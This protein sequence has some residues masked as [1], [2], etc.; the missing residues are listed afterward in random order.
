MAKFNKAA[1]AVSVG[2][3]API[4]TTG[5]VSR[6]HEGGVGF[7]TDSKSSLF[8]LASTNM[9]GEARFYESA[10]GRDNRF[11]DLVHQVTREDPEWMQ[12]FIPYLRNNMFMRS[13]SVAAACEYVAAGGPNGRAVINSA[14][15]RVDELAEVFGYWTANYDDR[16][17]LS[18][19]KRAPK[20]PAAVKRGLAD[21]CARLIN[22]YSAMKYDSSGSSIRLGDV[23]EV[24]HPKPL[25]A[26]QGS[27]FKYLLDKRHRGN[28]A[29]FTFEGISKV[30]AHH[31]LLGVSVEARRDLITANNASEMLNTAGFTWEQLSGWLQG[32]MDSVAWSAVIPSMAPMAL[33]RNLR[34]FDEAKITDSAYNSV[35]NRITDEEAIARAKM[36]P[37]RF[38]SAFKAAPTTR[39]AHPLETALGFACKNIPELS[40]RTLILIDY[41]GSMDSTITAKSTIHC[42]EAAALFG[43]AQF[44][45]SDRA[46]LV[47]FGQGSYQIPLSS[48]TDVLTGMKVCQDVFSANGGGIY[49]GR[50]HGNPAYPGAEKI[51]HA[52]NTMQAVQ[53][54]F[55]PKVHDRIVIFSDMQAWPGNV[56]AVAAIKVPVYSFDLGGYSRTHLPA[57]EKNSYLLSGFSDAAFT[58]MKVIED[59][60]HAD[61]PFM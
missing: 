26:A 7:E 22:E 20:L 2:K 30:A 58:M 57:G 11:R 55:N 35:V 28:Q 14:C 29:N 6:T 18:Y 56:S 23:L 25:N 41:S 1:S 39:W 4:R 33:I 59:G 40:G 49:S 48:G 12:G 13:A 8:R 9:C 3:T 42:W 34:N 54:H 21:A 53:K 51:G 36:F 61:W 45:R 44:V 37:F 17:G 10:A 27:L 46:D 31:Q 5:V 19:P 47:A 50:G 15:S 16:S 32:P 24:V 60:N 52:T 43:V 38:W